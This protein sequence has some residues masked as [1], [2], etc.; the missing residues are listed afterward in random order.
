[1]QDPVDKSPEQVV[2][3]ASTGVKDAP[4]KKKDPRAEA[5]AARVSSS[6]GAT[7]TIQYLHSVIAQILESQLTAT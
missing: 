6:Q 3:E 2:D 7:Y 4:Q 5:K 1:M